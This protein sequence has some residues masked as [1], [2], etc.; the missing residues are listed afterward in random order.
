M[1]IAWLQTKQ[2]C[3]DHDVGVFSH[4]DDDFLVFRAPLS[5]SRSRKLRANLSTTGSPSNAPQGSPWEVSVV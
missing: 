3:R 2:M 1:R 5:S 4:L